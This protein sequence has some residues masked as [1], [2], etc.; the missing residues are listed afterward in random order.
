MNRHY[1]LGEKSLEED[2]ERGSDT[3]QIFAA[4]VHEFLRKHKSDF[5]THSQVALMLALFVVFYL[6]SC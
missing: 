3:Q 6:A 4:L 1:Y 2:S 5:L